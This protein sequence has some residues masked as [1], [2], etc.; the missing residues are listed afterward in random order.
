MAMALRADVEKACRVAGEKRPVDLVYLSSLTMGDETLEA[1]VLQ[2]FASQLPHYVDL[3]RKGGTEDEIRKAAHTLKGAAKSIG[4]FKLS[5]IAKKA[6]DRGSL[7]MKALE[8]E[9]ES[10][11]DYISGLAL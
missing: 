3:L 7:D 4:A 2:M 1:E 6:E 5:D 10:V 11:L 9:V 8:Y